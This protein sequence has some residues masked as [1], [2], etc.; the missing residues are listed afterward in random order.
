MK[1]ESCVDCISLVE[2]E[3]GEWICDECQKCI[4]EIKRCPETGEEAEN[5]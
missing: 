3:N 4:E 5:K 2:G 1:R